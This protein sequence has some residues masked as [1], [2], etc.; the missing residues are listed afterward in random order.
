[1]YALDQDPVLKELLSHPAPLNNLSQKDV[2]EMFRTMPAETKAVFDQLLMRVQAAWAPFPGPQTMAYYSEADFLFYG[3]AAGGGKTDL[4]LGTAL[5]YRRAIIFRRVFPSLRAIIDRSRMMYNRGGVDVAK[6]SYNESLHRWKFKNGRY[7]RMASLQYEK[8]CTDYQGQPH[9]FYAFDEVPEFTEYMVRFVTTWLRPL[10]IRAHLKNGRKPRVILTGNPPTTAE[11]MWI[12][13]FFAPWL[14]ERHPNPAGVGE[15]RYFT[16]LKGKDIEVGPEPFMYEGE[17]IVPKSRTFIPALLKD[18]PA[19]ESTGYRAQLQQLPEPLRSKMLYGD[20]KA[21]ITDHPMQL[22]PTQWIRAAME[23]W[24]A[25]KEPNTPIDACGID[26]ARGGRDRTVVT[27][28]KGTYVCRQT[29]YEGKFTTDGDK[30]ATVVLQLTEPR[31]LCKVDVIG[32]GSSAYDSIKKVRKTAAMNA[33]QGTDQRDLS[34]LLRFRNAR[35]LWYW[36]VREALDPDKGLNLALPDDTELLADLAAPHFEVRSGVIQ[37]ESKE[38]IMD[39][40]GRSPDKGDSCVYVL[41]DP[42]TGSAQGLFDLLQM[43]YE[44]WQEEQGRLAKDYR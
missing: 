27:P 31:T 25:M 11:G 26:V 42:E 15:L 28:K 12:V 14:D 38:S 5:L 13:Q 29:V 6:D 24:R 4:I 17:L 2:E 41:A 19:L 44:Q 36:R 32:V 9:D 22:I 16:T 7:V 37:V 43:E 20:F 30:V 21:G 8:T 1:M 39:R 35:S 34:R 3:G 23:R 10:D 40:L 33:S 18:N